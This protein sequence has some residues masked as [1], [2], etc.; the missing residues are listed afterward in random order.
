MR[1][2]GVEGCG[3]RGVCYGGVVGE[4]RGDGGD[5]VVGDGEDGD[6]GLWEL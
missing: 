6:V 3:A 4:L 1:E 5:G 2:Q